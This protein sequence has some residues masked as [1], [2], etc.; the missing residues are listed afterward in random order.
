MRVKPFGS[1]WSTNRRR[2]STL[3]SVHSCAAL[4]GE[5]HAAHDVTYLHPRGGVV[6]QV[7]VSSCAGTPG[8]VVHRSARGRRSHGHGAF[9]ACSGPCSGATDAPI[10]SARCAGRCRSP[11]RGACPTHSTTARVSA[12]PWSARL[13]LGKIDFP[14]GRLSRQSVRSASVDRRR[15]SIGSR[16]AERPGSHS[17][18]RRNAQE[19]T[20]QQVTGC[21][22]DRP[23]LKLNGDACEEAL[24]DLVRE[25]AKY[26]VKGPSTS[27]H[28]F[29]T[30][31]ARHAASMHP[32]T[33]ARWTIATHKAQTIRR[34]V[35]VARERW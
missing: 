3:E 20:R 23:A 18:A 16:A 35:D 14:F 29:I 33:A 4:R 21:I 10:R 30:G 7:L 17:W 27:G 32:E 2:N 26:S 34:T 28:G 31:D 19:P 5:G 22:V 6:A 13:G 15:P 25:A 24:A 8:A 11:T 9:V 1:T 12:W